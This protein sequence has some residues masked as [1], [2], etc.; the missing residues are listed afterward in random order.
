[1]EEPCVLYSSSREDF[2][3]AISEFCDEKQTEEYLQWYD[4]VLSDDLGI[5]DP[6][7]DPQPEAPVHKCSSSSVVDPTN[8]GAVDCESYG[9]RWKWKWT[10]IT[11]SSFLNPN[12]RQRRMRGYTM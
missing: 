9:W 6:T 3:N 8:D 12:K 2:I 11:Q 10:V 7:L 5:G 1:M 4:I